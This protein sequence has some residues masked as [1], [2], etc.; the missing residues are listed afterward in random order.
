MKLLSKPICLFSS[1][2]LLFF[3]SC[4]N[5]KRISNFNQ[6]KDKGYIDL[7]YKQSAFTFS[8]GDIVKINL[9]NVDLQTLAIFTNFN[10]AGGGLVNHSGFLQLPTLGLIMVK[11]KSEFE[12][13]TEIENLLKDKK[14]ASNPAVEIMVMNKGISILGEVS[15]PG[16]IPF[17]GNGLTFPEALA[18]AGDFTGYAKRN[19]ILL[20][21]QEE[22]GLKYHRFSINDSSAFS[23]QVYFLKQNDIIYIEPN[24]AKV[25]TTSQSRAILGFITGVVS[26]FIIVTTLR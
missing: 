11:D 17:Q 13:K 6:L 26:L 12:L 7:N 3:G 4:L 25:F 18:L 23:N 21:R 1:F 5:S 15:R 24:S 16:R 14:I 10:N 8:A 2:L 22:N 9:A 20:I 19:N